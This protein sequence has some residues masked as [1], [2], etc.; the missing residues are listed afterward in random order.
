M[1]IFDDDDPYKRGLFSSLSPVSRSGSIFDADSGIGRQGYGPS[2]SPDY[3]TPLDPEEEQSVLSKV[4][5]A[6]LEGVSYI[7]GV[8][9]KTLGGRAV[10]GLLGGKPREALSIIPFS[11]TL[12]ITDPTQAVSGSELN[13][14]VGLNNLLGDGLL[15]TIG[16]IGTEILLDPSTYLTLGANALTKTGAKAAKFGYRIDDAARAAKGFENLDELRWYKDG[17]LYDRLKQTPYYSNDA[18]IVS[19]FVGKPLGGPVGYKIPFSSTQGALTG[20]IG[21]TVADLAGAGASAIGDAFNYGVSKIPIVNTMAPA[22]G[23]FLG[24]AGRIFGRMFNSDY[25]NAVTAEG[26]AINKAVNEGLPADIARVRQDKN[27]LRSKIADNLSEGEFVSWAQESGPDI[28]RA[29]SDLHSGINFRNS[30]EMHGLLGKDIDYLRTI[31]PDT[32]G[33]LSD[34]EILSRAQN[35]YNNSLD[36]IQG[37]VKNPTTGRMDPS[38]FAQSMRSLESSGAIPEVPRLN[39]PVYFG[40]GDVL[41][42]GSESY[43]PRRLNPDDRESQIVNSMFTKSPAS[44]LSRDLEESRKWKGLRNSLEVARM[45]KDPEIFA[46][47]SRF[48]GDAYDQALS[49]SM[50]KIATDYKGFASSAEFRQKLSEAEYLAKVYGVT[51]VTKLPD[52]SVNTYNVIRDILAAKASLSSKGISSSVFDSAFIPTK[53]A[54]LDAVRNPGKYNIQGAQKFGTY[55]NSAVDNYN[56]LNDAYDAMQKLGIN[57]AKN[58]VDNT[59]NLRNGLYYIDDAYRNKVRAAQE[60]RGIAEQA[61]KQSQFYLPM[62]AADA[63]GAMGASYFMNPLD[64]FEQKGIAAAKAARRSEEVTKKLLE[65]ATPTPQVRNGMSDVPLRQALTEANVDPERAVEYFADKYHTTGRLQDAKTNP[66]P[67][68]MRNYIKA[69]LPQRAQKVMDDMIQRGINV[70][71]MNQL[72][73]VWNEATKDIFRDFVY[74]GKNSEVFIPKQIANNIKEDL[75]SFAIPKPVNPLLKAFDSATNLLKGGMTFIAPAFHGRNIISGQLTNAS[76]GAIGNKLNPFQ[77]F[78]DSNKA[79]ALAMGNDVKGISDMPFFKDAN[80]IRAASGEALFNDATASQRM[81]ELMHEYGVYSP[82]RS[83]DIAITPADVAKP[84]MNEIPGAVPVKSGSDLAKG[85]WN[86]FQKDPNTG[87]WAFN[88]SSLLPIGRDDLGRLGSK[89]EGT[90]MLL[91]GRIKDRDFGMFKWGQDM[92][93][94]AENYNRGGAFL[95]YMNQGYSP[96]VAAKM[97]SDAHVD[98]SKLTDF[99]KTYMKRLFPFYTFTRRMLPFVAQ[100]VIDNPGGV[101]AQYAKVA[102]RLRD[103][104]YNNDLLPAH[105][106]SSMVYDVTDLPFI[107]GGNKPLGTR[108]FFT[109]L[110][111][112]IDVVGQYFPNIFGDN[113]FRTAESILGQLNPA[114]KALLELATGR[115]FFGHRSLDDLYSPTGDRLLD[116]IVGNSPFSRLASMARTATDDRKSIPTRA[117][118]LLLGGRFTDIDLPKWESV[119]ARELIKNELAG[120]PGIAQF[121]KVYVKP[122]QEEMLSPDQINLLRLQKNLEDEARYAKKQKKLQQQQ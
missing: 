61:A 58:I 40:N 121:Q 30:T 2:I 15:G 84:L 4:G 45:A 24:K 37:A 59:G 94:K 17:V 69:E 106:G 27:V 79:N 82:A 12:G 52:I 19:D 104:D 72:S 68:F 47:S 20:D 114:P 109:G 97:V 108:T 21:S 16:G 49:K 116:Q 89:I 76:A 7:G 26:Q 101:M 35:I 105:L 86:L 70:T 122:G 56:L 74:H 54:I 38:Y 118:N 67:E 87:K 8:L 55:T 90:D 57:D 44:I 6:A 100:N 98:Y 32:I 22:A 46:L 39:D 34:N 33:K 99:E 28:S 102:G 64:A 111:L 96:E 66:L 60:V 107:S 77:T 10:R 75:V 103:G 110:E 9:D 91:P 95:S 53:Q 63:P 117:L 62:T 93:L 81:R 5:N 25:D 92:N 71:S 18:N 85:F 51:D 42:R 78:L 80:A 36:A 13:K 115:Q 3:R 88:P 83:S 73:N 14:N 119:R 11:D 31:F 43:F 1:G 41:V 48:A 50:D 113:K 120:S 112:P 23:E 65:N 29:M